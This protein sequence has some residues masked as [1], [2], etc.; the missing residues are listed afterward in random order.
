VINRRINSDG[1]LYSFGQGHV[2]IKVR[3]AYSARV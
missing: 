2:K 3:V 1:F